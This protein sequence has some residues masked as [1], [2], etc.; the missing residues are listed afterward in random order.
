MPIRYGDI[1]SYGSQ[2]AYRMIGRNGAG[3]REGTVAASVLRP[4]F[5]FRVS[6]HLVFAQ[7]GGESRTQ[8]GD[9]HDLQVPL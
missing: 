4:G 2:I 9:G 7:S 5:S 8:K 6:A 1:D 3:H